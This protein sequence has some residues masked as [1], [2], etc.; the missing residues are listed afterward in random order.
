MRDQ[1]AGGASAYAYEM[2]TKG[3]TALI[4]DI[5]PL[6]MFYMRY[7]LQRFKSCLGERRQLEGKVYW[8]LG[9][10]VTFGKRPEE[11]EQGF[12]AIDAGNISD[13][14][15]PLAR[16]EQLN[17]GYDKHGNVN[18]VT[19]WPQTKLLPLDETLKVVT[20]LHRQL[21]QGGWCLRRPDR[22]PAIEDT[23]AMRE[24]LRFLP[25]P[26]SYWQGGGKFKVE[27]AFSVC[28][29]IAARMTSAFASIWNSPSPQ[30]PSAQ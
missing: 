16:H 7:G 19:I 13:G 20:D 2:L 21:R 14:V 15:E 29:A 28:V 23:P 17:V 25:S 12:E 6:H 3:N 5:W 27:I 11:I 10:A 18:S 8:P 30:M 24:K 1:G 4:F 26:I 9:K 22:F